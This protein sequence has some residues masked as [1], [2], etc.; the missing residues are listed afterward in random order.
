[1]RR[2]WEASDH[3][4]EGGEEIMMPQD[5]QRGALEIC[6]SVGDCDHARE[7]ACEDIDHLNTRTC[8]SQLRWI[9]ARP[10]AARIFC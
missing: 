4:G 1:M 9:T 3:G 5:W 10:S 7:V 2:E 6:G 8:A